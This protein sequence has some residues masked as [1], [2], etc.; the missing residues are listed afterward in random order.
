MKQ[1]EQLFI[2]NLANTKNDIMQGIVERQDRR[3]IYVNLEQKSK[4][5]YQKTRSNAK[6][7]FYQPHDRIKVYV[8]RVENTSKGP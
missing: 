7:N 3:Y 1:K 2:M 6:M 5:S 4:Q 8:S